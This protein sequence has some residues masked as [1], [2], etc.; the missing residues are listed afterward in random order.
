MTNIEKILN[1]LQDAA[2]DDIC[3]ILPDKIKDYIDKSKIIPQSVKWHPEFFVYNHIKIVTNRAKRT[4]NLNLTLAAIFHDL[5]KM[6]CTKKHPTIP[7]KWTTHGHE[8]ISAR[9]VSEHKEWIKSIG[10]DFDLIYF[11][12]DQHMRVKQL[13]E[14]KA[15][16]RHQLENHV[17]YKHLAIFVDFDNMQ[18]DYSN[19]LN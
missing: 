6:E 9:I 3:A 18:L 13:S 12:V 10:G 19:D 14:M 8:K 11:I 4:G 17:W 5:G 15:H 7:Y 1:N 16:K 2:F